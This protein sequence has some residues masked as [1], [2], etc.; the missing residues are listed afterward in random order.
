M[1]KPQPLEPHKIARIFPAM[2]KADFARLVADIRT[3]GLHEPI[4][5]FEGGI[6]DGCHRYRACQEAGIKPRFK[7]FKG[8]FA[9]ADK[10]AWS[11]N[12]ERRHLT[13]SQIAGIDE[14]RQRIN[15]AYKAEVD[16]KK[17]AALKRKS[18]AGKSA[19]PGRT[20]MMC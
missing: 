12:R 15:P 17:A 20:M 2:D 4:V 1:E 5:T 8:D 11:E 16:A 19:A 14:K 9:A 13:S 18:D 3:H 10:F 6:L 7:T